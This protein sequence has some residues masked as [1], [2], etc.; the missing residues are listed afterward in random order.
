MLELLSKCWEGATEEQEGSICSIQGK[1]VS[2]VGGRAALLHY[3]ETT[4]IG[5]GGTDD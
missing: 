1:E 5:G 2:G 3:G 4:V